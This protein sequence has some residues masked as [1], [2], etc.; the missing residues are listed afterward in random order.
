VWVIKKADITKDIGLTNYDV[1][2]CVIDEIQM[3]GDVVDRG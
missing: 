2:V 1:D 3:L